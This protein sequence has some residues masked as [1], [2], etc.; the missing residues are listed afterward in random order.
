M[1]PPIT[2]MKNDAQ[3]KPNAGRAGFSGRVVVRLIVLVILAYTVGAG[4]NR[5]GVALDEGG[6]PAGFSRGVVQGALMPMAFPNLLVGRD[7][8]IY[9]ANNTGVSYKLGYTTGVNVCGAIF[10]GFFFW[11]LRRLRRWASTRPES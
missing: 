7:V 6:R 4:L 2:E 10:F 8:T 1:M 3:A 5:L 9:S 11:R